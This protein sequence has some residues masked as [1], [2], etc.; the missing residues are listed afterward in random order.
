MTADLYGLTALTL[1]RR[2]EL[3]SAVAVPVVVAVHKRDHPLAGL[4]LAGKRTARVIRPVLCFS[5]QQ[6]GLRVVVGH[7]WFGEGSE[8][9]Q[10]LKSAFERGSTHGVAVVRVQDQR[11]PM[12][13]ADPLPDAGSTH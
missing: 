5:E 2:H 12:A 1:V 9:T 7:S 8:H 13:L 6:F 4:V 3:D 10:F 11:L